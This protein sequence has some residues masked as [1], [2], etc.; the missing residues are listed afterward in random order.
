MMNGVLHKS[1]IQLLDT[2]CNL[3][4]KKNSP[5][6]D[7]LFALSLIELANAETINYLN[8]NCVL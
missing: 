7:F 5:A 8:L 2:K 3:H 6:C 1:F 4:W